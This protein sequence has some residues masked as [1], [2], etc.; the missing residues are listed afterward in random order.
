GGGGFKFYTLAPSLL[1]Q[2]K[3]GNWVISQEYNADML[4]AAMAKQ[5]GFKYQPHENN[6]WKQG[7]SSEHD[8]IFTTTQ[9]V[10][11]E[12]LDSIKDEMLPGETLL[13]CCKSFQ[14]ECLGK[15][16][17]ITM[18]KIPLILLGRC[19]FGKE[20]Y[21]LNIINLPKSESESEDDQNDLQTIEDKRSVQ[22]IVR[23]NKKNK[24]DDTPTLFD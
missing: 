14:K 13:I 21:S 24:K 16:N 1:K 3:F 20:D 19:E 11:V 6:Y 2:D 12:T 22:E 15:F 8:Y 5:E 9:F 17:N 7:Q 18:K 4:A 23:I 10:T